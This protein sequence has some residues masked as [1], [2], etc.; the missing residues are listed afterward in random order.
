VTDVTPL[1][2]VGKG[3]EPEA[4]N[5]T[6]KGLSPYLLR[7]LAN[8]YLEK[9]EKKRRATGTVQQQVLNAEL[10]VVLAEHGVLAEFAE[11]EFE[12]VMEAVCTPLGQR[13]GR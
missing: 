4:A 12:R 13:A 6:D 8:W 9:F 11:I 5:D 10:R 7:Q 2:E 1:S 3:P